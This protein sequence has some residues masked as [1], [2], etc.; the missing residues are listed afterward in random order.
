MTTPEH[1]SPAVSC[2][3]GAG[4]SLVWGAVMIGG[5]ILLAYAGSFSV[6]LLLDDES[7]ILANPSIRGPW[8]LAKFLSP[9]ADATTGGRPLLNLTFAINHAISGVEPWSYHVINLAIH[10]L[11]SLVLF[12][13]VRLTLLLPSLRTRW[14]QS[15]S[16]FAGLVALL[17]ALH[18]AQT[19]SV[20]YISQR[21]ESLMGL[22]Y[23]TTLYCFIR[24]LEGRARVW[25]SL[26]VAACLLGALTKEVIV[27]APLMV[28]LYDRTFA[29]GTFAEALRRRKRVYVGLGLTWVVL[30]WLMLDLRHRGVGFSHGVSVFHYALT[31]CESVCIYVRLGLWPHPLIFDRG[32]G[33]ITAAREVLP[34]GVL[35]AV[36]LTTAFWACLR[37]PAL[38]FVL[39]WFFV[40]LAPTSS[41]VPVTGA[42]VAENRIYLPLVALVVLVVLAL[43]ALLSVRWVRVWGVGLSLAAA[44]STYARNRDYS[45]AVGLWQDTVAKAPSNPRA[46]NNLALLLAG[47]PGRQAEARAGYVEAL[48]VDPHYAEAHSNLGNLLAEMPGGRSDAIAHY[49]EALRLNPDLAATHSNLASVLMALPGHQDEALAHF[50]TALRLKPNLADAHSNFASLLMALPDRRDEALE[51]FATALRLRP[52]LVAA[53]NN[54]GLLLKAIPG[55]QDEA[56]VQFEEALRIRPDYVEARY[57]LA[58]LMA[59]M[60]G[61]QLDA[62]DHYREAARLLPNHPVV[63]FNYA[64]QLEITGGAKSEVAALYA[65]VLALDPNL[66]AAR[67]ALERL[68][69]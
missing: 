8:A 48:R 68:R 17:W 65:K 6:P 47:M 56:R 66:A 29:A 16:W 32:S 40:L 20:T 46:H 12:G 7:A 50:S 58:N 34:Q 62:L 30:G 52:D 13:A 35:L 9:P 69:Q 24:G 14:K 63:Q 26:A 45:S 27:T 59:G 33:L 15:A 10:V 2:D 21:A 18:P 23:L 57:N 25:H 22:F 3:G 61:R 64:R 49:R 11:G 44:L 51:H 31:Q 67:E 28:L 4:R 36:G 19:Q 60:P 42:T 37:R 39:L 41:V 54:L 55:R 1:R 43:H 5:A 53:R 38:G